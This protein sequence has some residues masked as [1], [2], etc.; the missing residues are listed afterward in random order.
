MSVSIN[1]V[2]EVIN[3]DNQEYIAALYLKT[4]LENSF[5][6]QTDGSIGIA[7]GLTLRGQEV[8]DIDLLLF[9]E[10]KN[11][12]LSNYYT[13]NPS[14]H[15]KDLKVDSFCIAIELK[16]HPY[17]RVRYEATH[18]EVDYNGSWKDATEQNEKQRYACAT[19]LKSCVGYKVYTTNFIWLKGLTKEQL[20]SISNGNGIGALSANFSFNDVIDTIINQGQNPLYN[21]IDKCY[22]ITSNSC[23]NF[24]SDIKECLFASKT[25][26]NTLTRKKLETLLQKEINNN[27]PNGTECDGVTILKGRAGTGKTFHLIQSAL[28]LAN[29]ES[30]KRCVILTYNHALVS[31]IRRLLHFM[32]IPDGIDNHTIQIQTLHKFFIGL[33]KTLKI[34]TSQITRA[35]FDEKKYL[36]CLNILLELIKKTISSNNIKTLKQAKNLPIDWDY[37]L[38]D[39]AQDWL[40]SEKEILYNIYGEDHIIIADGVDQFMRG[41]IHQ[42]W[43]N[44][45]AQQNLI[46]LNVG[47]RQKT[48][49]VNFVNAFA[50]MVGVKWS[51]ENS[52]SEL[53]AG[54]R[55]I[56]VDQYDSDLHIEL[57]SQCKEAG[58]DS[59]DMLFLVPYQMAPNSTNR[60]ITPINLTTWNDAGIKLFDGTKSDK[61]QYSINVDECRLYQYDSCRGL[62]GWA[63][64]CFKFDIL[65]ENKLKAAKHLQ[66]NEELALRSKEDKINE[67]A[68]LWSL[69]P[70]TRAI[71]TLVITL[72]NSESKVGQILKKMADSEFADIIEWKCIEQ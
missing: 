53:L 3:K 43:A 13:N 44:T 51:V 8:R 61:E 56:V 16:E 24:F 46:K 17:N 57:L 32:D 42:R 54:G 15:K 26:I 9:G 50:Q 31:D 55:I 2:N 7:Y 49:L 40:D 23:N 1:I 65:I 62:E 72:H 45:Y 33:M 29:E 35:G 58:G 6:D 69:M 64:I 27:I 67:Y 20:E 25:P 11:Y 71:D 34:D 47:M 18:V 68:Y 22:H 21:N 48:N 36:E 14:Y 66:F 19:Y 60:T 30:M 63:T 4:L 59:Y 38:V 41:N 5:S 12:T 70:L 28:N 39:E 37:V 10:L 52:V